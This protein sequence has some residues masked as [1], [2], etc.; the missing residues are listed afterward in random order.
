ML[1]L[2]F[3]GALPRQHFE[4]FEKNAV[5]NF[6]EI[7]KNRNKNFEETHEARGNDC[8]AQ[9]GDD[10]H[11]GRCRHGAAHAPDGTVSKRNTLLSLEEPAQPG[12]DR[13]DATDHRVGAIQRSF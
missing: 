7:E 11:V 6:E 9:P 4:D 5:L 3:H 10:A 13:I 1:F 8:T 2:S 12:G